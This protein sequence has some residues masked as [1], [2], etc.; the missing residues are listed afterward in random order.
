MSDDR[1]AFPPVGSERGVATPISASGG[2]RFSMPDGAE[3]L[4]EPVSHLSALAQQF[5]PGTPGLAL[6]ALF[7]K[8]VL[9]GGETWSL[10]V[11]RGGELLGGA[12][13]VIER[14]RVNAKL[15]ITA[16]E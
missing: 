9:G 12:F 6:S 2:E 8:A 5:W 7:A 1:A 11:S 4:C 13:A 10:S 16:V 15:T 14:G 3:M